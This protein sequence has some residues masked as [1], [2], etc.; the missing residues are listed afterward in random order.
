MVNENWKPLNYVPTKIFRPLRKF[1]V[2]FFIE[3]KLS[4]LFLVKLDVIDQMK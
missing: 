3:I 4:V 1:A 2:K